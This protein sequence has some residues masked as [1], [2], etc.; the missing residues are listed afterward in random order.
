MQNSCNFACYR[1]SLCHSRV[2]NIHFPPPDNHCLK[3]S[4]DLAGAGLPF[5]HFITAPQVLIV[6]IFGSHKGVVHCRSHGAKKTPS[7][8]GQI[9]KSGL[10]SYRNYN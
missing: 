9:F 10:H 6:A 2:K 3:N 7:H 5:V 1:N 8:Q 4:D